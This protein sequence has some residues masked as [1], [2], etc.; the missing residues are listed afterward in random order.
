MK[1]DTHR[2]HSFEGPLTY[3]YHQMVGFSAIMEFFEADNV[4]AAL[5]KAQHLNRRINEERH[6]SFPVGSKFNPGTYQ[7]AIRHERDLLW[8]YD[9]ATDRKATEYSEEVEPIVVSADWNRG[10]EKGYDSGY[11]HA[12][13]DVEAVG[14]QARKDRENRHPIHSPSYDD[15]WLDGYHWACGELV[16]K[17]EKSDE[18]DD[19]KG[20]DSGYAEGYDQALSDIEQ[21][22]KRPPDRSERDDFGFW[23]DHGYQKA[24]AD[25][26][27]F[28][29]EYNKLDRYSQKELD[30][31]FAPERDH[32]VAGMSNDD[33]TKIDNPL[34]PSDDWQDGFAC[35]FKAAGKGERR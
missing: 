31:R 13:I 20:Y 21:L 22:A 26:D 34:R 7:L 5:D 28:A 4:S 14:E 15:G 1:T 17:F 33:R 12:L 35:G 30:G 32:A 18:C 8:I 10:W 29:E 23:I 25:I 9:S 24:L 27:R 16:R 6:T 11:A 19:D 3:R 2:L